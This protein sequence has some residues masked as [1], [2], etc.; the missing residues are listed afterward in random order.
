MKQTIRFTLNFIILL[1]VFQ[2]SA[3]QTCFG[4][5]IK[6][7]SGYEIASYNAKGKLQSKSI[8]TFKE[9]KK[10]KDFTVIDIE[11]ENFSSKGKSEGKNTYSAKCNGE[12]LIVDNM[13]MM[14]S[15]QLKSM[16]DFNMT[17][18]GKGLER[19]ASFKVGDKLPNATMTGKG[20]SSSLDVT[21]EL[22]IT[23]RKVDS[24][25]QLTTPMGSFN[26]YKITAD[27]DTKIVTVIPVKLEYQIVSYIS[28]GQI[29]E[30]RTETYRKGKL[31]GYS[32]LVRTF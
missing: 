15:E 9:V 19:P 16:E 26:S 23:N 30:L 25:Q 20:N 6:K 1:V 13:S 4:L 14:T 27:L 22:N 31:M 28:P 3:A 11:M 32:E 5:E 2:P 17:F 7:G 18:S 8:Y 12:K 21:F 10:E 29:W 24:Q